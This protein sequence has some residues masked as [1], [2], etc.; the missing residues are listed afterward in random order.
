MQKRG[1]VIILLSA[2]FFSCNEDPKNVSA[3]SPVIDSGTKEAIPVF[4]VT[5]YLLGQLH[6]LERSPVTP[7]E[8]NSRNGKVDSTWI[9]REDVRTL[10]APFLTPAIDSASLRAGFTGNSFLDQTVNAVT[11]TYSAKPGTAQELSEINVYV[12]PQTNE[13]D[14]IYLVKERGD[15]TLQL[16]WKAGNWFSIRRIYEGQVSEK[17]VKWQFDEKE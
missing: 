5:D 13:V 15:T 7:L 9:T 17:K 12:Q 3:V 8:T 16:T 1:L 2:L 10:A 4:P 14:R 11:F 6:V